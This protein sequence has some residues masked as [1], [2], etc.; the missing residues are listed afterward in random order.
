M[1]F[2][3]GHP[4]GEP[5]RE[6]TGIPQ[7]ALREAG[8]SRPLTSSIFGMQAARLE[9]PDPPSPGCRQRLLP[10]QRLDG[11]ESP[12][13]APDRTRRRC[14]PEAENPPHADGVRRHERGQPA[15][16]PR[17][18]RRRPPAEPISRVRSVTE[19]SMMFMMPMPPTSSETGAIAASSIVITGVASAVAAIS[20]RLRIV[21]SSSWSPLIRWRWR[22]SCVISRCRFDVLVGDLDEIGRRAR[23]PTA[24]STSLR[25]A[26][27]ARNDDDVVLILAEGAG[28]SAPARR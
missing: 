7:H 5:I 3:C 9:D 15:G 1:V 18:R 24:P 10:P 14:R 8:E 23:F 11:I 20:D 27:R 25:P 21:K 4:G 26:S 2:T 6:R 12:R 19:T 13:A 16:A 17:D 22:S 28:P